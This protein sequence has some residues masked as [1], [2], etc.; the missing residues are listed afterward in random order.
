MSTG[1]PTVLILGHSFVKRLKHDLRSHFDPQADSNYKLGGTASVHLHGVGERT[2]AKLWLFNLHVVE[3]IA[4][5]VLILEIGT[6]DLV[7]TS[8]EVLGSKIE[9]MVCPLLESYLVRI[10]CVCHVIPHGLSHN[11]AASFAERV[12]IR[13]Q[14]LNV[15]L[16]P[17][18]NVFLWL[19]VKPVGQYHLNHSYRGV[20]LRAL[21]MLQ[22]FLFTFFAFFEFFT[23]S[24][25]QPRTNH[26]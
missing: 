22:E 12:E 24:T 6:N 25:P 26:C 5:D 2:V 21:G 23:S 1:F 10:V 16:S 17:I 13:Q 8:P 14:Y 20:I 15:V 4:P 9:S 11:N 18:P 7:D 19:H 3:P